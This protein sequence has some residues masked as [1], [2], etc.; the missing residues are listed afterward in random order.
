MINFM[1][2]TKG[3][4]RTKFYD[5]SYF[6]LMKNVSRNGEK[7]KLYDFSNIKIVEQTEHKT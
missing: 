2:M 3:N 5:I 1:T 4:P 6:S 7:S